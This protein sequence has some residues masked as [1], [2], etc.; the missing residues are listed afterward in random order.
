LLH[1]FDLKE[2]I[3]I[4]RDSKSIN[5]LL[6][7]FGPFVDRRRYLIEEKSGDAFGGE[8]EIYHFIPV[9]KELGLDVIVQ[10]PHSG[11]TAVVVSHRDKY[12]VVRADE[13]CETLKVI[14]PK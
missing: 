14:S 8:T 11:L 12:H 6:L 13:D 7:A 2:L 10:L 9:H 5:I 1:D 3:L 4:T